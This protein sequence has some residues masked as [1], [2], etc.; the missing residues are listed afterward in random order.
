MAGGKETPRQKMIGM[1][2]LVLTA[3]LAMNVSKEVINA[4]VT[5]NDGQQ[6]T[7]SAVDAKLG[8]QMNDL[9]KN[10]NENKDKYGPAHGKAKKVQDKADELVKHIDLIKAKTFA[11]SI[12]GPQGAVEDVYDPNTM[13]FIIGLDSVKALVGVD[14]YDN[15]TNLMVG[16][17]DNPK[18]DDDPDGNNYSATVLREELIAF[19]DLVIGEL[20]GVPGSDQIIKNIEKTF[21]FPT[22]EEAREI[23]GRGKNAEGWVIKNFY[24]VPLAASTAILTTL[25]SNIRSAQSDVVD[26]L[27]KEVEGASYKFNKLESAVIP[28]ATTVTQ[29]A[30]YQADVF[31]AA[32]DDQNTPI[33]YLGNP[34]VTVD[35]TKSPIELTGEYTEVEVDPVTKM[36]KV[37]IAASGLGA[38]QREGII[39]FKP[40]GL[41]EER[42]AF[43]LDYQVVAPQL[44][45]S[46]TKMNVFYKGIPNP[47]SVSVP[48]F[49]DDKITPRISNGSMSKSSEGYIVNVSQGNTANITCTAELPDGT[50]KSLGPVEFRVKR[51]PDP[52]PSFA[53]KKPTDATIKKQD[54]VN[55][56]GLRAEMENFDFDVKVTVKSFDMVF[57]RDGN[58]ITK[59]S[60]SNRVTS[61]MQ[62]NMKKVRNGEKV[63]FENIKVSMPDGSVRKV[64]N[65]I[66]KVV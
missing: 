14:N 34:G 40:V 56:A 22:D 39:I 21:T 41:P 32:Y 5:I 20:Q 27:Y 17:P 61:E 43:T 4:F 3:L 26:L 31:L 62:A 50:T 44:V 37:D 1:M 33:I 51:I 35:S 54:L 57:V 25:Q 45:V 29:G 53:K 2:Y 30:N 11:I 52:V 42:K 38:Q 10:A 28:V 24:H 49:T 59:K 47:V 6:K 55:S 63:Y 19:K 8:V 65:I 46:P 23:A 36:G 12:N 64:A 15:N 7:L 58:V 48:G 66:L 18:V 60:S 9:S 13:S 16:E